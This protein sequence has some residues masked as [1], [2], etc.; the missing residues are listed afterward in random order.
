[1]RDHAPAS[2][3]PRVAR[4]DATATAVRALQ[5]GDCPRNGVTADAGNDAVVTA[6][7]PVERPLVVAPTDEDLPVFLRRKSR[8]AIAERDDP[9]SAEMAV[10]STVSQESNDS[11]RSLVGAGAR[12][13]QQLAVLLVQNRV[14]QADHLLDLCVAVRP[15]LGI[16]LTAALVAR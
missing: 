12:C 1:C 7:Q 15:E 16:K 4:R 5:R 11:R 10:E 6:D 9:S 2:D 3:L 8:N 14:R 13:D